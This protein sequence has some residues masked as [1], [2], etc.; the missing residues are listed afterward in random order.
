LR[1]GLPVV[2]AVERHDA[3]FIEALRIIEA[4]QVDAEPQTAQNRCLAVPVL[5]T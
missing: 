2:T 5:K 4:A 3:H 1:L